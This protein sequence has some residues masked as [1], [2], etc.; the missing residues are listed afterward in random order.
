MVQDEKFR[1]VPEYYHWMFLD[2][3]TPEE[4][5]YANKQ[6]MRQELSDDDEEEFEMRILST[7]KKL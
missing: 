3:Y 2:G 1:N 6:R 4:V 5:Y 7:I